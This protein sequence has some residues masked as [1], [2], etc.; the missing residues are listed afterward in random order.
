MTKQ[1]AQKGASL[2]ISARNVKE[3]ER[4]KSEC[5]DPSKITVFPL[6]M[7]KPY[8]VIEKS[9]EFIKKLEKEGKKL[10]I[11]VQ[12]AGVSQR[13]S[14]LEYDFANHEYMT[15]LNYHGPVAHTKAVLEH[16]ISNKS[17][18]IVVVNSI[19]GLLTPGYRTSYVGSK[20]ALTGFFGSLRC[21][22]R[23]APDSRITNFRLK[24]NKGNGRGRRSAGRRYGGRR[25]GASEPASS[26]ISQ[27]FRLFSLNAPSFYL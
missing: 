5:V 23:D 21:E 4:V 2:I 8:E 27:R 17:G 13:S 15:N 7:S 11:I 9:A 16:L 3:L 20:H 18:Q 24:L 26:R 10:D 6:D 14:F 12:N 1:F 22:V 25:S 19:S